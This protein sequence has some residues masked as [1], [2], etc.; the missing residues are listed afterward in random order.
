MLFGQLEKYHISSARF[1][2]FFSCGERANF[3]MLLLCA[4]KIDITLISNQTFRIFSVLM[5]VSLAFSRPNKS[6]CHI[7]RMIISDILSTIGH[8]NGELELENYVLCG[9]S[10]EKESTNDRQRH[11]SASPAH[12]FGC[13]INILFQTL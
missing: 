12:H 1:F 5:C 8:V 3:V 4:S 6:Y 7:S 11:S 2:V 9:K 10:G 13:V